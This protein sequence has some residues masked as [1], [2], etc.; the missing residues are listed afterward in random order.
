MMARILYGAHSYGAVKIIGPGGKVRIGKFCSIADGVTIIM[1]EHHPEWVTTY[2]FSSRHMNA[3]WPEAGGIVGQPFTK[4]PVIIENDVWIGNGATILSGVTIRSG[5]VIAARSVV[6]KDIPP[7]A[8]VAG[9]PARVV[10][11]RFDPLEIDALM[12]IAWWSW[13]EEKI[14]DNVRLLC[15]EN[16]DEFIRRHLN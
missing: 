12:Q 1:S 4:G 11:Y 7:Y 2:P 14:R 5:A 9:N 10:K 3:A 15:S 13:P 6:A 16:I 8:V